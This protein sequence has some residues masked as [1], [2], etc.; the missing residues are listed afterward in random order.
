MAAVRVGFS[1]DTCNGENGLNQ[2][3]VSQKNMD[4]DVKLSQYDITSSSG[5]GYLL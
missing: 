1:F 5:P 4:N 2:E 3:K